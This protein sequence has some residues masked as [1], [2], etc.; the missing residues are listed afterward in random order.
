MFYPPAWRKLST[1]TDIFVYTVKYTINVYSN[2]DQYI[3][4]TGKYIL[5]TGKKS[6]HGCTT[7][8]TEFSLEYTSWDLSGSK[9]R[10]NRSW[11]VNVC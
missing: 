9:N 10:G 3:Y 1:N 2:N 4:S 5:T 11:S 6:D 7:S 8:W